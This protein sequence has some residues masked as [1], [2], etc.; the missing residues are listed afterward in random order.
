[1][2]SI[3]NKL[4][5][6]AITTFMA[7]P[8]SASADWY[9]SYELAFGK[10]NSGFSSNMDL[11]DYDTEKEAENKLNSASGVRLSVGDYLTENIRIYAYV[12]GG[13]GRY[14][15][16]GVTREILDIDGKNIIGIAGHKTDFKKSDN[17]LGLGADYLYQLNKSWSLIARG[18]IG[19]YKS[20]L[21]YSRVIEVIG[22]PGMKDEVS[23]NSKTEGLA[24]GLNTGVG[25][26]QS[27]SW[28]VER[29]IKYAVLDNNEH[30]IRY[31]ADYLRYNFKDAT[32]HHLNTSYIF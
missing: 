23:L 3:T 10:Y 17:E 22:M 27:D 13:E 24:Y 12:S 9:G 32:Q 8:T 20:K 21:S 31:E 16:S 11:N 19:Y 5:L 30:T 4:T 7:L 15:V 29:G 6:A 18:S 25:P 14:E 26:N 1:V 28:S 2:S